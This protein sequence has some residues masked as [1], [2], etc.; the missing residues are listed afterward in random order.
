[1][2]GQIP[3]FFTIAD[4]QLQGALTSAVTAATT[5]ALSAVQQPL[6]LA[7]VIW[8]FVVGVAVLVG[9]MDSGEAFATLFRA[10][11]VIALLGTSALYTTYVQQLFMTD[12]PAFIAQVATGSTSSSVSSPQQFDL[13]FSAS[14]H[15]G[16]AILDQATIWSA[17][18]IGAWIVVMLVESF[19]L[20]AMVVS[21]VVYELAQVFTGL[22]VAIGPL[23][24]I[25]L[26]FKA[27]AAYALRFMD[28]LVGLS[29]LS[30]LISVLMEILIAG[31]GAF[32]RQMQ[33][34]QGTSIAVETTVFIMV[35]AFFFLGAV[36]MLMLPGTAVAIGGGAALNASMVMGLMVGP[37][38]SKASSAAR[39]V[40]APR[41]PKP[42]GAPAPVPFI[43]T[44]TRP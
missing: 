17:A 6:S 5:H 2:A 40:P 13:L 12:I 24:M 37:I 32:M 41:A 27:T 43:P 29:I 39:P 23:V 38:L 10:G 26:L 33:S 36:L 15:M 35:F 34:L 42:Q 44:T 20:A 7:L 28:K 22:V 3:Q 30:L 16:G 9:K 25:G 14:M 1:M 18:S 8:A 4:A 21:F 11:V 19:I 31:Q